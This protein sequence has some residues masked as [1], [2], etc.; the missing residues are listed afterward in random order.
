[1]IFQ[2]CRYGT[3]QKYSKFIECHVWTCLNMVEP[4]STRAVCL[5]GPGDS[6][7]SNIWA[8]SA[9]QTGNLLSLPCL[10]VCPHHSSGGKLTGKA[11]KA[12]RHA[13]TWFLQLSYLSC[14]NW[15]ILGF[16][17]CLWVGWLVGG[18]VD[19]TTGWRMDVIGGLVDSMVDLP[20]QNK[21]QSSMR[22]AFPCIPAFPRSSPEA[23][24]FGEKYEK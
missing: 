20:Q 13:M 21:S 19:G 18:L 16:S 22:T 1:M 7:H 3:A 5:A 17:D 10:P 2:R 12:Y 4:S 6:P 24:H 11:G 15:L 23:T 14:Q 8:R 9:K